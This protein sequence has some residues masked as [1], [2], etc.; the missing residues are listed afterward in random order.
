MAI[1]RHGA[2]QM[3]KLR[4]DCGQIRKNIGV[5]EFQIVQHRNLRPVMH[6]LRSLVEKGGVIFIRLDHKPGGIGEPRRLP[7][8]GRNAANQEP[9]VAA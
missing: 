6:E 1:T 8:I 9:G 4:L 5:V 2:H 7:E 3:M